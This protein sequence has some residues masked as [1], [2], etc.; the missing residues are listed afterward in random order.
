MAFV[1]VGLVYFRVCSGARTVD[2]APAQTSHSISEDIPYSASPVAEAPT[3]VPTEFEGRPLTD[4]D[5]E[6]LK[7]GVLSVEFMYAVLAGLSAT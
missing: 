4:M 7:F 5:R 3:F 2:V 6:W 1:L